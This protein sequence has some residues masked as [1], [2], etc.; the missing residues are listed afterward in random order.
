MGKKEELF[1]EHAEWT[2]RYVEADDRFKALLPKVANLS[3]G[4]KL[5]PWIPTPEILAKID[6]AEKEVNEAQEK[7]RE[8]RHEISKLP[9]EKK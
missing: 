8:I 2:R 3:I 1:K 9:Q 4:E 6:N 7:L 5:E